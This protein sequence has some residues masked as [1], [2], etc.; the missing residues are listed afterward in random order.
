MKPSADFRLKTVYVRVDLVEGM[1]EKLKSLHENENSVKWLTGCFGYNFL[2]KSGWEEK[3]TSE[4][5]LLT[6]LFESA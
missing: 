1:I 2:E 3:V 5:F 6:L 4:K